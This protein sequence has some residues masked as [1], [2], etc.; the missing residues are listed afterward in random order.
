MVI[1]AE[2]MIGVQAKGLDYSLS[3]IAG[4]IIPA[5]WQ[6][7]S[8]ILIIVIVGSILYIVRLGIKL[9]IAL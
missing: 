3:W 9:W 1:R 8:L 5:Q 6:S 2:P 4:Q 7:R